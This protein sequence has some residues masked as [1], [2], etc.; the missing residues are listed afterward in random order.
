MPKIDRMCEYGWACVIRTSEDN[1][2]LPGSEHADVPD[3]FDA[4]GRRS[5]TSDGALSNT[6]RTHKTRCKFRQARPREGPNGLISEDNLAFPSLNAVM[7]CIESARLSFDSV[8]P[9][10]ARVTR[11]ASQGVRPERV[12]W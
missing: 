5:R 3:M 8:Q 9:K 1:S 10:G 2:Q 4:Q 7:T 11:G 6:A 12:G